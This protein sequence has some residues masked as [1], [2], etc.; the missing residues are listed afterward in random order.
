MVRDGF[1]PVIAHT[2]AFR[3]HHEE[4]ARAND[5]QCRFCHV[6]TVNAQQDNCSG[7]HSAM[8]PR[9]H[10]VVRF[11]ETTHGRLAAMDRKDCV[12]CHTSDY[13]NRCHNIPPR[14]HFPLATFRQGLHRNLAMLNLRSCFVCHTFENT[15]I[16]CHQQAS[17][18]PRK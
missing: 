10:M 13:C 14:S 2:E 9:S 17:M 5:N 18:V 12:T 8:R 11:N 7:C 6:E 3:R 1:S 4:A 15:C 16:E